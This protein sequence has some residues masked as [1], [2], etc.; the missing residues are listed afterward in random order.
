LE[1]GG[2][3]TVLKRPL[4][5]GLKAR[6]AIVPEKTLGREKKTKSERGGVELAMTSE[7]QLL[8]ESKE[9]TFY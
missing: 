3:G 8:G 6:P 2:K 1:G 5:R 9:K 7:G 4:C